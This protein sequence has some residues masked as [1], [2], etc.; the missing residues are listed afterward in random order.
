LQLAVQL[1]D[2]LL[3]FNRRILERTSGQGCSTG[4][5]PEDATTITAIEAAEQRIDK[6]PAA[7]EK[8][9]DVPG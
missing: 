8:R 1:P 6:F 9:R 5:T 3:V 4:K 2:P 7:I